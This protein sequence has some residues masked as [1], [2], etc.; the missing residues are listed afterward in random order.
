MLGYGPVVAGVTIGLL[1]VSRERGNAIS[2][3]RLHR[4]SFLP[5]EQLASK[6]VVS[7]ME[8]QLTGHLLRFISL[9]CLLSYLKKVVCFVFYAFL[10]ALV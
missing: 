1:T 6:E 9:F 3:H 2:G 4:N 5:E 8:Y 10:C 7:S